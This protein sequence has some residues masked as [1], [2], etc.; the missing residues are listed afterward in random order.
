M[1][2]EAIH[3]DRV[4]TPPGKAGDP[5][6]RMGVQLDASNVPI[7]Y[8]V[9][10]TH[11]GDTL[12]YKETFTYYPAVSSNGLPRMIHKFIRYDDG[13]HRGYPR[14]QVGTRRLKNAD[15]YN[16][17]ELERVYVAAC[18]AAVVYTELPPDEAMEASGAVID[19]DGKR[20]RDMS[21]GQFHYVGA[22]DRV[23]FNNPSGPSNTFE[24]FMENEARMFAAGAGTSYELLAN[25]WKGL[26]YSAGKILW[27]AED[28]TIDVLQL[29]LT[30]AILDVWRNF[31][32]RCVISSRSIV[33]V[34]QVAFRSEPWHWF[35]VRVIPPRKRSIDPARE[36][37]NDMTKA[38]AGIIPVSDLVEKANGQPADKVYARIERDRANRRKH[39]L[40]IHMPNMGRDEQGGGSNSSPTQPG[41]TNEKSSDANSDAPSS[42]AAGAAT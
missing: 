36:D 32:T 6:V 26:T 38:E 29:Y 9:R 20:V 21:P 40:E 19:A 16:E 15:E 11:P 34:D 33:D 17:A 23:E 41:D 13:Q 3:P 4:D 2:L 10:D 25:N 31:V 28:G 30:E 42:Q 27:N 35:A 14:M 1:K 24:P 18:N 39:G 37:R 8:Y 22:T 5:K 12:E 7:G